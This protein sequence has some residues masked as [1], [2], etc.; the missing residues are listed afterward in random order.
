MAPRDLAVRDCVTKRARVRYVEAGAGP[1]LLL[2]HDFLSSY[3]E[4]DRLLGPL[5]EEFHVIAPDLP[6][7]GESE[8]PPASRFAYRAEDFAESMLDVLAAAGEAR[9][10]VCGHGLGGAVALAL[11]A[12]HPHVVDKLVLV[13]PSVPGTRPV[14][15][16]RVAPL[17]L[18]G[19]LL[20]K[21]LWGR[22]LF[23]AHF[24]NHVFGG[25]ARTCAPLDELFSHFDSPQGRE[26]AYATL[27]A[28]LDARSLE[29]RLPRV[30][31]RSLV[32][33]GR[34]DRTG[35]PTLGRKVARELRGAR[36]EVLEAGHSPAEEAPEAMARV[37]TRFVHGK[38][39][40]R[41]A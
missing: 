9:V 2:I 14:A 28:M 25:Q 13:S 39:S 33:W 38:N 10:S 22:T 17:P 36:C 26:S 40:E 34:G 31:A 18:V 3:K 5:A 23:G 35:P 15:L 24:H 7:F 29:A 19:P 37:V 27:L 20:F 41:A 21:Q 32:V 4:H 12:S 16:A 8:K 11:A 6:G 30:Q 1:G